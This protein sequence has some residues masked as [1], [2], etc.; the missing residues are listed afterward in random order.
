MDRDT[1]PSSQAQREQMRAAL[2][3]RLRAFPF[4]HFV[5]L[6]TNGA[7]IAYPGAR[8]LLREWD[9]RVNRRLNGP[10]WVKRPDERLVWIAFPEKMEGNFHWHLVVEVDPEI[11]NPSRK[12][13]TDRLDVAAKMAWLDTFP[14]RR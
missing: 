9:A 14:C 13:R 1:P 4:T 2:R 5:T 7:E 3:E 6:A 11:K 8:R 10:K 12:A